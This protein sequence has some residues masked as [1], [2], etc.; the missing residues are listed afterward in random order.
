M[1]MLRPCTYC[2]CLNINSFNRSIRLFL[3]C[4]CIFY[5]TLVFLVVLFFCATKEKRREKRERKRLQFPSTII[6]LHIKKKRYFKMKFSFV[7]LCGV[8]V[9]C[10]QPHSPPEV[11][12]IIVTSLF[13][14]I[15]TLM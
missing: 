6:L 3:F 9:R 1:F 14:V 2:I 13:Y 12:N 8:N 4:C 7:C 11:R 5:E 10:R 15:F